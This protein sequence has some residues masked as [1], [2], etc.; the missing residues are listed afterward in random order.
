MSALSTN[1]LS[2]FDDSNLALTPDLYAPIRG[3]DGE[4]EDSLR[5]Y[6][7]Q[8]GLRCGCGTKHTFAKRASFMTHIQTK[9]HKDWI[10]GMNKN[11]ANYYNECVEL[12]ELMN[13]Q[14]LIIARL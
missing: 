12:R 3:D 11:T 14:K 8:A 7:F 5:G 6:K 9:Q 10:A 1:Q 13:S 2:P 4:F